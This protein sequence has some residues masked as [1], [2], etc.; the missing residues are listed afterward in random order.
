MHVNLGD[1]DDTGGV[2]DDKFL[3]NGCM[4]LINSSS[5]SR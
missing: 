4:K 5:T 1:I 3:I 2:K